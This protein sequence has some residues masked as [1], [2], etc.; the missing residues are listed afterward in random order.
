MDLIEK[1]DNKNVRSFVYTWESL[2]FFPLMYISH[3]AG[4]IGIHITIPRNVL[5]NITF[6][7][8]AGLELRFYLSLIPE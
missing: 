6:L 7:A 3:I 4:M 5:I 1:T 8:Q 2:Q